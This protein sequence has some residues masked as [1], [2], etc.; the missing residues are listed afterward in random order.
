MCVD[1]S[2]CTSSFENIFPSGQVSEIDTELG[3]IRQTLHPNLKYEKDGL[4][5]HCIIISHVHTS[6]LPHSVIWT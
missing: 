2:L 5:L 3:V 6:D 4:N 1:D